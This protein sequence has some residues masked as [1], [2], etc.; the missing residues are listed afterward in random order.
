MWLRLRHGMLEL[1]SQLILHAPAVAASHDEFWDDRKGFQV[2]GTSDFALSD[3][4]RCCCALFLLGPVPVLNRVTVEWVLES[5]ESEQ[6]GALFSF[7]CRF[8]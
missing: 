4:C 8:T 5:I 3:G 1:W 6:F 7:T 2:T